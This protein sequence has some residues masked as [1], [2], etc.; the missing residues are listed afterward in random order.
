[1]PPPLST[2]ARDLIIDP[3]PDA[4][5]ASVKAEILRR[6]TRSA[7]SRFNELIQGEELGDRTPSEFLRSLRASSGGSTDMPL[8]RE[9]F[10]SK[11]PSSIRKIFDTALEDITVDQL[12]T[13]ADK[14]L[15]IYGHPSSHSAASDKSSPLSYDAISDKLD[16]LTR[17]MDA[18]CRD[19]RRC[20]RSRSRSASRTPQSHSGLCWYHSKFAGKAHTCIQPCSFKPWRN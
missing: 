15:E 9:I 17:Q 10:F 3:N 14:V 1:M 16:V 4:T 2:S 6:N 5:Y 18:L 12:A 20:S 7:E 19:Y 13:M 11:L 8:F